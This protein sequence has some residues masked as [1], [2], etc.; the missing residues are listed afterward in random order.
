MKTLRDQLARK[1]EDAIHKAFSQKISEPVQA[2]IAIC[3]QKELGDYQ[4]NNAMKL[5]KILRLSP[6][7]IAKKIVSCVDLSE[8]QKPSL[9]AKMEVAHPG[10]INIF[11][12]PEYLSSELNQM[13]QDPYLGI[14]K[15]QKM[16][17]VVDFSSPNVAKELH[18][19]HLRSTI[20]GD[21]IANLF[22]FLGHDVLRL[23]HIGDWGTQFGM[24]IAYMKKTHLSIKENVDTAE[25]TIWYK[26]AKK[27][28]DE[29]PIFAQVARSE[30]R[31]LQDGDPQSIEIWKKICN[32]SRK[33]FH[34]IY[35]FLGINIIER[36][37][38]FYNPY[39]KQI[40]DDCEKKKLVT[41]SEGAKCIMLENYKNRE[42][43]P[44]PI[45]IQKSDGAYNY[46]TTD[47]A[48]FWH[49]CQIEEADRIIIV[50]DQGQSLHF[51]MIYDAAIL[52]GYID[53]QKT[54]FDHVGFGLVLGPDGK[55]FKTRSGET[56]KLIDLLK[57]AVFTAKNILKER[58]PDISDTELNEMAKILGMAAIKYADLSCHRLKDYS[59][60]YERMLS[61][62]GNTAA[63]L[64]Y[65]YVRILGIKRKTGKEDKKIQALIKAQHP[66]EIALG[67]HLRRFSEILDMMAQELL[68]NRLSDYLY[69]LAE[70][71]NAF[72]RDCRVEGSV[73]EEQRLALCELTAHVLEKG[74]HLLGIK[75]M[76]RM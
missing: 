13:L 76:K 2:E 65:A 30:V 39:L 6:L 9:I 41:I 48:G 29:D 59:F 26:Q 63:F 4:C 45:I 46:D 70:K 3:L 36:G 43:N 72:F 5:A 51:K 64:L 34:E 1:F 31:L 62:E 24:L 57:E 74:L 73:E 10:F 75:T 23:N 8:N 38:S 20:I 68:P 66:Q 58:L 28:F 16:K 11:I 21:S 18:V 47:L 27:L 37:E 54:R 22:E 60:S 32:I 12:H 14:D 69:E 53:P 33:A 67:L 35:E 50:T 61:F 56:E 17:I 25:L 49:R 44:L 55:K 40:V 15:N 42:G 52:A 71:F 7:E 19:G